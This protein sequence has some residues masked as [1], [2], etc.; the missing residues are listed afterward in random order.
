MEDNNSQST[1]PTSSTDQT[2]TTQ[3]VPSVE[4][5]AATEPAATE[6]PTVAES[7]QT[8][9]APQVEQPTAD[10]PKPKENM[11]K[12][13]PLKKVGMIVAALLLVLAIPASAYAGYTNSKQKSDKKIAALNT[14]IATLESGE[15]ELPEG[16]IKVS[17]CI[18]NM[19]YHYITKTSDKEYGPFLLVT[20]KNKVIGVEYM[21]DKDMYT[22]I[23]KTDP[24]VEVVLKNSP[25]FGWKFDHTE[26]SHAPKGHEGLLVDH[27]DV[28]NYTVT[29]D[30]QK[31]ACI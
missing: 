2:P 31:Q 9:A 22:A 27:I 1:T 21:A 4:S 25:M 30:Q 11:L 19:G 6:T 10:A 14:Q 16:A 17:D 26:F 8:E 23:P 20:K 29:A 3:L 15:H 24:P 5:T 7:T 18:P 28:H 13:L 12:K